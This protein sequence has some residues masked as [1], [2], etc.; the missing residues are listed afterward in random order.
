MDKSIITHRLDLVVSLID[1]TTG[2]AVSERNV[3]FLS[4][5]KAVPFIFK[6]FGTYILMNSDRKDTIYEIE[7]AGFEKETISVEYG[8]SLKKA[9]T[10]YVNLVPKLTSYTYS[11]LIT[12]EGSLKGIESID[13]VELKRNDRL[14]QSF[15]PRNNVMNFFGGGELTEQTYGLINERECYFQTINIRKKLEKLSVMLREPLEGTISVGSPIKR[16][17]KG[18]ILSDDR[19]LL[20]VRDDGQ[21][22]VYLVRYS[23][24]G[25]E[26]FKMI[27]FKNDQERTLE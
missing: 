8:E 9:P 18:K 7:V 4:D 26:K 17:V 3:A 27:N 20:R 25:N 16:I 13:A 1:T 15:Q 23:I 12:L 2:L 11:S 19:Y 5:G 21:E 6:G 14:F 24:E 22:T 10:I